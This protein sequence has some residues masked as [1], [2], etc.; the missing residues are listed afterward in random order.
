MFMKIVIYAFAVIGCLTLLAGCVAYTPAYYGAPISPYGIQP[1]VAPYGG[2]GYSYGVAPILPVPYFG[3]G[4]RG[5][6]GGYGGF[7][8]H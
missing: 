8:H 4:G 1:Q 2:Y 7:R 5:G 3:F 6:R